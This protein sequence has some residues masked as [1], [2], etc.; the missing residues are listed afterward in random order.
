MSM[1]FDPKSRELALHFLSDYE[2][3]LENDVRDLAETIQHAV[4]DWLECRFNGERK[5]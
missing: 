5:A 1:T 4:E 2:P 3:V